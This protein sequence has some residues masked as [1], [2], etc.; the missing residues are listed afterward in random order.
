MREFIVIFLVVRADI[1]LPD[2][3]YHRLKHDVGTPGALRTRV[4]GIEHHSIW[5][6]PGKDICSDNRMP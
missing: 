3:G 6:H 1:P 2:C 5:S 4:S